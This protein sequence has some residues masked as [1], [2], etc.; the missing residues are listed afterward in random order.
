MLGI[1]RWLLG[2]WALFY[3]ILLT[4]VVE[5]S[6]TYL[7]I[8]QDLFLLCHT[9][10]LVKGIEIL[11]H[12]VAVDAMFCVEPLSS[13]GM[14]LLDASLA[15]VGLRVLQEHHEWHHRE[16]HQ[17]DNDLELALLVDLLL[18]T[19]VE[20]LRLLKYVCV[21]IGPESYDGLPLLQLGELQAELWVAHWGLLRIRC[22]RRDIR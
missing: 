8:L 11:S 4:V 16:Y 14:Q 19:E 21:A 18:E 2:T 7:L 20:V 9:I 1:V 10:D 22:R 17:G 6:L 5:G 12:L 15:E 3:A 13:L